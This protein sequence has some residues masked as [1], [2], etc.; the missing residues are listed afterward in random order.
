MKKRVSIKNPAIFAII[1]FVAIIGVSFGLV[2]SA[3]ASSNSQAVAREEQTEAAVVAETTAAETQMVV[4]EQ[5]TETKASVKEM[6]IVET[7]EP[8]PAE[9]AA[10]AEET[11]PAEEVV[12]EPVVE[13][14]TATGSLAYVTEDQV[15]FR[16]APNS[17]DPDNIIYVLYYGSTHRVVGTDGA[18]TIIN[19]DGFGEGYVYSNYVYLTDDGTV[20]TYAQVVAAANG[21]Q[22]AGNDEMGLAEAEEE[23]VVETRETA[24]EVVVEEEETEES[25]SDYA[26]ITENDVNFRSSMSTRGRD[27]IITTLNAG[28]T[29]YALG[30]DGPWV[31]IYVDGYGEGYVSYAYVDF[32]DDGQITYYDE[33]TAAPE[34]EYV[35]E[36]YVEEYVE[37]DYVE[38]Y[39]EDDYV[40][41][42]VEYEDPNMALRQAVVDYAC[43]FAG[44]LPYVWGS[45]SLEYGADCSGFTAA[46]YA[47]FGYS[48]SYS[49][50]VQSTQGYSVPVSE[51]LPG[52]IIVYSGHVAMYVGDGLKVH[53]PYPGTVVTIDSAYYTT[54]LDVRRI[55]G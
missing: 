46:V 4:Q 31:R 2:F 15:N 38:E 34:E 32:A 8:A 51:M 3:V 21:A 35:E 47:Q 23:E 5:E 29:H 27:N 43:S 40:E 42:E 53:S 45:H 16:S 19:V 44:W 6:P 41:E 37:D 17:D 1:S 24:E 11:A 10:P 52:D 54:I 26:V 48:L 33:M 50:D 28:T 49:S 13:A 18:W 30:I 20:S 39:V 7:E 9:E 36:D 22:A 25:V 55:I 14:T 12:E